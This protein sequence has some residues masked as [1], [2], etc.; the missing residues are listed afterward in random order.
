M[1]RSRSSLVLLLA[2]SPLSQAF[3]VVGIPGSSTG[4]CAANPRA[5]STPVMFDRP[6]GARQK[7]MPKGVPPAIADRI[8]FATSGVKTANQ[9]EEVGILWKTFKACYANEKLAVEAVTRNA[10][11]LQPQYNSPRKIKGTYK[12]LQKRFGKK[13]ATDIIT[14]NPGVLICSP[15][16]MEKQ[17]D[18]EIMKAVALVEWTYENKGAINVASQLY[19]IFLIIFISYGVTAKGHC[20][21]GLWLFGMG[22]PFDFA[23]GVPYCDVPPM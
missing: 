19:G 10:A 4:Q 3:H 1:L 12:L 17:S 15:E 11:V 14:R 16:S 22:S 2:V 13:G 20:E 6:S 9:I 7:E 18:D 23:W 5:A 8:S 21:Y